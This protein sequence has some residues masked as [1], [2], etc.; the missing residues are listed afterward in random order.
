MGGS[1]ERLIVRRLFHTSE[2]PE[3][4]VFDPRPAPSGPDIG[5]I[6]W[7]IDESHLVNYL[8]PRDCPRVTFRASTQTSAIDRK[9]FNVPGEEQVVMVERGWWQAITEKVLYLYEL[10]PESFVLHDQDAGYWIAREPVRPLSITMIGNLPA[11][12]QA[13]GGELRVIDRL[14]D[15]HDVVA[16]STLSFSIIRMRNAAK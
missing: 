1:C 14:W 6:V 12:I 10:P 8:L 5:S 13:R 15:I 2:E 9:R 3:L 4:T 16:A 11:A 7:A